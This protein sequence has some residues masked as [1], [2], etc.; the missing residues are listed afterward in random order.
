VINMKDKY[1]C[2]SCGVDHSGGCPCPGCGLNAVTHETKSMNDQT[3]HVPDTSKMVHD[4]AQLATLWEL[5]DEGKAEWWP[6]QLNYDEGNMISGWWYTYDNIT[7][8][9]MEEHHALDIVRGS[10]ERWLVSHGWFRGNN[11]RWLHIEDYKDSPYSV[12]DDNLSI[13]DAIRAETNRRRT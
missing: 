13:T 7:S 10:A 1:V 8:A 12:D 11:L 5:S 6:E 9:S 2:G 4:Q 3:D